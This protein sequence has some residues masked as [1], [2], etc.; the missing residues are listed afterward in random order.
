MKQLLQKLFLE[1]IVKPANADYKTQ[2]YSSKEVEI[3][4]K[5]VGL[6]WF[7]ILK[8]KGKEQTFCKLGRFASCSRKSY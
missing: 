8:Y 2:V 5:F 7:N 3:Q 4:G 1:K 6:I